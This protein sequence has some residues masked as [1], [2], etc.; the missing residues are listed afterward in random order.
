MPF[1]KM[2]IAWKRTA[3]LDKRE[4]E[5]TGKQGRRKQKGQ[6]RNMSH[7]MVREI[8]IL[9]VEKGQG[10]N[11]TIHH[12]SPKQRET[13]EKGIKMHTSIY[14]QLKS[15]KIKSSWVKSPSV[16]SQRKGCKGQ[17]LH[18]FFPYENK[19][20]SFPD[21]SSNSQNIYKKEKECGFPK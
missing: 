20:C 1:L 14:P 11:F 5:G 13:H 19:S 10:N 3:K 8:H 9:R 16:K 21:Q 6:G 18:S 17:Q 2:K 12:T 7:H 15:S 4:A